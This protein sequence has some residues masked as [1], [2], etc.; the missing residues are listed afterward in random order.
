MQRGGCAIIT[1][2]NRQTAS[3]PAEHRQIDWAAVLF[4]FIWNYHSLRYCIASTIFG[5]LACSIPFFIAVHFADDDDDDFLSL[6]GRFQFHGIQR[7]YSYATHFAHTIYYNVLKYNPRAHDARYFHT[8]IQLSSAQFCWHHAFLPFSSHPH[9]NTLVRRSNYL[10]L[11]VWLMFFFRVRWFFE[12]ANHTHHQ[13]GQR[14]LIK[15]I[16]FFLSSMCLLLDKVN[17]MQSIY[18]GRSHIPQRSRKESIEQQQ[19]V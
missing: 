4:V 18:T 10:F 5:S 15:V 1:H 11:C 6:P 13:V 14:Q 7:F 2:M 9:T 16:F 19:S 17:V 12:H 3:Q 8:L